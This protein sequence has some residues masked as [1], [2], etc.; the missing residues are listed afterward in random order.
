MKSPSRNDIQSICRAMAEVR[1][2]NDIEAIQS[3]W[4]QLLVFLKKYPQFSNEQAVNQLESALDE[5]RSLENL[6]KFMH[7]KR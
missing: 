6:V 2:F 1:D 5:A 3:M 7:A 4:S